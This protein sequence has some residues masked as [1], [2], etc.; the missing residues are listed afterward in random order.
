MFSVVTRGR[1]PSGPP[2]SNPILIVPFIA[3]HVVID[4]DQIAVTVVTGCMAG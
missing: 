2:P 1:I 4:E 3:I